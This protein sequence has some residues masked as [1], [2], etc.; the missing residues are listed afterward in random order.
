MSESETVTD[1]DIPDL[2][3]HPGSFWKR[4]RV[5]ADDLDGFH[6]VNN[7]VYLKWLDAT[8][9]EHTRH[10]GLSE[11]ACLELNRGMA[12]ARHEI[13]Y[14]SSARLEDEV[15]V[16]NWVS[17]NDHRL[18]ASRR[19]QVVRLRDGQTI[20]RAKSDY[21]CTNLTNGRPARMPEIFKTAYP[22]TFPEQ[23]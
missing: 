17:L 9:W 5:T 18:R 6:H 7:T 16:F 20:L 21:V 1:A 11:E 19:F 3:D 12:V 15:V 14:L 8:V 23:E 13:D 4:F 2:A 22:V 10:V